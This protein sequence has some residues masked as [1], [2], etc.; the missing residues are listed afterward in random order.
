[1]IFEYCRDTVP[2]WNSISISGYHIREAG[3]TAAQELAFTLANAITYVEAAVAKGLPVDSF[4]PRLSFFF[5][6]H[7][8]FFEEI[9]KFR[10]ARRMWARIMRDRFGAK[11]PNSMRLRFHSQTAGVTLT[12]QQ[13]ENNIVRVSMQALASVLGG[14]QSLHTNSMD[15]ALGLPTEKAATIALRTQQIL[16]FETGVT[17]TVDPL[18]GSY[19]VESLTDKVELAAADYLE[20]INARGGM[21]KCIESGWVQREIQ[22]SAYKDQKNLDSHAR[23]VV[24]VNA[25]LAVE[26]PIETMKIDSKIEKDQVRRLQAF[27]KKRDA[28]KVAKHLEK[29]TAAAG[30]KTNLIPLYVD[31]VDDGVTLGEISDALRKVFG[32]YRESV[33]V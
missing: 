8:Y 23:T 21:I 26:P 16:A 11:N 10:A 19:F 13:P 28:K 15:E 33:T 20:K 7:N 12:A 31:A 30:S 2:N 17:D 9:A 27:K 5:N 6:V 22:N 29:I 3:S 24:G 18:A 32:L 1:D 14:T 4:A 25:F